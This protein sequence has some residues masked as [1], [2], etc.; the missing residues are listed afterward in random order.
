MQQGATK[1]PR[2]RR[3]ENFEDCL[4]LC[5]QAQV[6]SE[7]ESFHHHAATTFHAANSTTR[8]GDNVKAQ[9]TM[10]RAAGAADT[11]ANNP[12]TLHALLAIF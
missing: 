11:D 6:S 2:A 8:Q 12:L 3:S 7:G 5:H 1:T 10:Q 9:I 4:M